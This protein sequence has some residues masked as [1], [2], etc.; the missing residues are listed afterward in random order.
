MPDLV[1]HR[2]LLA[3]GEDDADG[4]TGRASER[5]DVRLVVE[6]ALAAE[7]APEVAHDHTH[8]VLRDLERLG[9]H[10][11]GGEGH[12]ARRVDRHAIAAPLGKDRVGLDRDRVDHVR[13]VALADHDVGSAQR[14]GRVALHDRRA[15]GHVALGDDLSVLRI[16]RPVLV[17]EGRTR[18]ERALHVEDKRQVLVLDLDRAQRRVRCLGG[19]RGHGGDDLALVADDVACEQRPVGDEA[20]RRVQP[21]RHV[22][23][24]DDGEHARPRPGRGH[25]EP[26]DPRVRPAGDEEPPV[27]HSRRGEVSRVVGLSG[28][29]GR[30]VCPGEWSLDRRG[31]A[32]PPHLALVLRAG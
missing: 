21:I 19:C 13:D 3:P 10:G 14:R 20:G 4:P 26:A 11:A 8:A 28:R 32:V 25:V 29:L 16:A 27:R 18:L 23:G 30:P 2:E 7:P 6:V 31:H 17:D 15:G 9:H 12:L 5:R 24:R 22:R 1:R